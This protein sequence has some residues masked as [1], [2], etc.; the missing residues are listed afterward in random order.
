MK[1]LAEEE[2]TVSLHVVHV[3][4]Q[5]QVVHVSDVSPT[6]SKY[7]EHVV[8]MNI[9]K[10]QGAQPWVQWCQLLQKGQHVD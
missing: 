2:N 5:S 6:A 8:V 1:Y 9:L 3:A 10:M 7:S 4:A